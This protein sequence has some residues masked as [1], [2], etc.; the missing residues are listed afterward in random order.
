M[1]DGA[2]RTL[3]RQP[4]QSDG[5]R[6]RERERE[7]SGSRR[8]LAAMIP[9]L[10][11]AAMGRGTIPWPHNAARTTISEGAERPGPTP[12]H[13]HARLL[14]P[15]PLAHAHARAIEWETTGPGL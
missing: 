5:G 2:E 7:A 13:V 14:R 8:D 3:G 15:R 4:M 1:L 10:Q 9:Y 6:E 11:R 12:M